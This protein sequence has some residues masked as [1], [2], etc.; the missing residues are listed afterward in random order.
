[1]WIKNVKIIWELCR[2][3]PDLMHTLITCK[4]IK[5]CYREV[6]KVI[7]KIFN[8]SIKAEEMDMERTWIEI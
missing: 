6:V 8:I 3:I 1:M 2:D 4:G 5:E 7:E